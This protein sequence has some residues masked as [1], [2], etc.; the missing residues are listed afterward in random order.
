MNIPNSEKLVDETCIYSVNVQIDFPEE[1]GNPGAIVDMINGDRLH[2]EIDNNF[3][4]LIKIS[5]PSDDLAYVK[6]I[7]NGF[8]VF[9]IR[10]CITFDGDIELLKRVVKTVQYTVYH[11]YMMISYRKRQRAKL[12]KKFNNATLVN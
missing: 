5:N 3:D 12:S 9:C 2:N 1:W 11:S 8:D 7:S 6:N 10:V 4:W